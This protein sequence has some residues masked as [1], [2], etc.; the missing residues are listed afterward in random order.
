MLPPGEHFFPFSTDGANKP[1]D[2]NSF[3]VIMSFIDSADHAWTRGLQGRLEK[4]DLTPDG[5]LPFGFN[6]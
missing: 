3:Y 4:L 2:E 5:R 6:W 1:D